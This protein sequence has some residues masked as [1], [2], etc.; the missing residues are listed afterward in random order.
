[1]W[2]VADNKIGFVVGIGAMELV[3]F[4][5]QLS[6]TA[7]IVALVASI[8]SFVG[9]AVGLLIA[10]RLL[11]KRPTEMT[12]SD[13]RAIQSPGDSGALDAQAPAFEV[14]AL[15]NYYNQALSAAKI[16]F[17]FSLG[18]ASIGFGVII[19]AFVSHSAADMAGTVL[20]VVSGTIIDAV[21][22][23][24][25]VQ[26]TAAQ[27]SMSEFFDKLRLDRLNVEA[28]DLIAQ[29]ENSERRDQLRAQLVLKYAG[30]NQLLQG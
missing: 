29:I 5:T 10:A 26:S 23:L 27:K 28:R 12:S 7:D 3:E 11:R 18:F 1:M 19:F 4:S 25:F 21:A 22:G 13:V 30:I 17:W 9:G 6:Q 14:T 16:S 2:Y 15:A 8:L 24:F 20:K